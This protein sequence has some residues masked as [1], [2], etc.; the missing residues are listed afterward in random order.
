MN[1]KNTTVSKIINGLYVKK[2]K[3]S[4]IQKFAK[5]KGFLLTEYQPVQFKFSAK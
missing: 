1:E 5:Y 4:Q 3:P 2:A